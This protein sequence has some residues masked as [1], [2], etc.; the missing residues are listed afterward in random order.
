MPIHTTHFS[1]CHDPFHAKMAASSGARF[2]RPD[3]QGPFWYVMKAAT[4][5]MLLRQGHFMHMF[6]CGFHAAA[7]PSMLLSCA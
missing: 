4:Q 1:L 6:Q 2:W 3:L 5:C 7:Q